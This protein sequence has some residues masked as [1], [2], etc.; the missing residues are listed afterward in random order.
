MQELAV[1][2]GRGPAFILAGPGS[3]KTFVL[4][5]HIAYLVTKCRVPPS[6]LLVLT[7][8]RAAALEMRERYHKL[9][10]EAGDSVPDPDKV[11]F[12]TFHSVFLQILKNASDTPIRVLDEKQKFQLIRTILHSLPGGCPSPEDPEQIQ[13][14]SSLLSRIK[15]T[16]KLYPEDGTLAP[17]LQRDLVRGYETYLRSHSL[18]DFDDMV[19]RTLG[20][21][22]SD[23]ALLSFWQRRF[24]YCLVDEFQDISPAQYEV[25]RLISQGNLYC[26]GDDDQSIYGFRGAAPD[27]VQ[28]FFRDYPDADRIV[29]DLNFR[30]PQD[31]VQAS[32]RVIRVNENRIR[33][34]FRS[35]K[36]GQGQSDAVR[37][38][39]CRDIADEYE[40]VVTRLLQIRKEEGER[41]WDECAVIF[42]THLGAQGLLRILKDRGIPV[43]GEKLVGKALEK[44]VLRMVLAWYT[45]ASGA[46][47]NPRGGARPELLLA[48]IPWIGDAELQSSLELVR[49]LS[50]AH[51]FA[52]LRKS[53][54]M[55]DC[56]LNG[57][58]DEEQLL[59]RVTFERL[60]HLAA[61]A[62]AA[63]EFARLLK[64]RLL[65]PED[66]SGYFY[67][68]EG[69]G[70][71][72]L[73]ERGAERG[74]L[75]EEEGPGNSESLCG[76][77]HV[78]TMHAS[79]GLEFN[80]VFLP[81]LNEGIV[82][83]RRAES[84]EQIEEERR[85]FYVAMTR[86]KEELVLTWTAGTVTSPRRPTRFLEP[87]IGKPDY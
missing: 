74:H 56:L 32:L 35:A 52:Y 50:P 78:I 48:G 17:S 8:S 4:V 71:Q 75:P 81:D 14:I 61:G 5:H 42:R 39:A 57:R 44:K 3:G 21:L 49:S 43:T 73:K 12:G 62:A 86:A 76:S 55:E 24:T 30:S 84:P 70:G 63:G 87:L 2:R 28:K 47:R 83:M 27:N 20:L 7:F 31:V 6:N 85:L 1:T 33:K 23:P 65:E 9:C 59:I 66:G 77:V 29:L 34:N 82:P 10:R 53:L 45:A 79:K 64:Q 46:D 26:V 72:S 37:L 25:V 60:A 36:D 68:A 67:R 54:H 69:P 15:S 38:I 80:H 13:N 51:S 40:R 18:I 19:I 11:T 16:G 22:K 41:A 58:K